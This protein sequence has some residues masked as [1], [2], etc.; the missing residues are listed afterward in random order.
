M[1][2][3]RKKLKLNSLAYSREF[4]IDRSTGIHLM[5]IVDHI[6]QWSGVEKRRLPAPTPV[7]RVATKLITGRSPKPAIDLEPYA[8]VGYI[9]EHVMTRADK[10]EH[11]M[12][13]EAMRI[14]MLN[15][16]SLVF[17]GEQ[18][19]CKQ[20]DR[21]MQGGRR[22]RRHCRKRG[23][24]GIYFTP[25]AY[26]YVNRQYVEWKFTWKSS[27]RSHPRVLDSAQGI[28]RW[29]VQCMFNCYG[30]GVT[31]ARLIALHSNGD[32]SP[33]LPTPE[34]Y[35]ITMKFTERELLRNKRMIVVNAENEGWI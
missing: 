32:Y 1:L 5:T 8:T 15:K 25:D 13:V 24:R 23:H 12:S 11:A 20:C 2:I 16:P 27:R 31:E 9:W 4:D 18:F 19:W 22:A 33:G 29:P 34:P 35:E 3:T 7:Q 6:G 17:P 28:W 10:L 30:L 26:D 21:C 14:M